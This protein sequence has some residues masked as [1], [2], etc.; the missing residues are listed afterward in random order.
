ME[1]FEDELEQVRET[2]EKESAEEKEDFEMRVRNKMRSLK[3]K[4]S[5]IQFLQS[6]KT[7]FGTNFAI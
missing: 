4:T 2:M 1:E 5:Y 3:L 6:K 7:S